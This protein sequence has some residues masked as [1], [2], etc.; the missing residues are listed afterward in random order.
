MKALLAAA[1]LALPLA[2]GAVTVVGDGIPAALDGL[3]CDATRG[4]AI[5]AKIGRAHV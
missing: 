5:V 3:V 4:R 2:G 1:L